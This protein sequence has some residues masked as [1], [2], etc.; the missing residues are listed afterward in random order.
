MN[1]LGILIEISRLSEAAM[2]IAIKTTK[3]P[4]LITNAVPLSLCNS[5][6]LATIPD[7]ILR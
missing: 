5:S 6:L 7:H 2:I 1:R 3:A 4:I